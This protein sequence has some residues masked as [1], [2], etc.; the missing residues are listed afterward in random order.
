MRAKEFVIN[1]PIHITLNGDGQPVIST[2]AKP[3]DQEDQAGTMVPPLQ[4]KIELMKAAAGKD[5][6]V[7][8]QLT[9]DEDDPYES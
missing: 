5:S 8:D 4:Q 7:I 9:A 2:D 1:I 3:E 6:S